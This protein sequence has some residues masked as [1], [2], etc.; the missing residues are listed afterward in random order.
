MQREKLNL[1]T[2]TKDLTAQLKVRGKVRGKSD[3][4]SKTNKGPQRII[5]ETPYFTGA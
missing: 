2:L 5:A 1:I 3:F 4:R